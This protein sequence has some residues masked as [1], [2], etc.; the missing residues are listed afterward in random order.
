[1]P[2]PSAFYREEYAEAARGGYS[3]EDELTFPKR[4]AA[5]L[6]AVGPGPKRVLDFGCGTGAG[7]KLLIA[8]GHTVTGVDASESGIQLARAQVPSGT[9]HHLDD[10]SDLPFENATFDACVC[11]EV[12]EHLLDVRGFLSEMHRVLVP[13]GILFIT[14]PY[15]GWLKNLLLITMNFDRHFN[16]TGEHIRFFSRPSLVA[17]LT[18]AGF[19]VEQFGGIGRFWPVWKSMFVVA[20]NQS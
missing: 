5:A 18:E 12:I 9:F 13:G 10:E 16:A 17:C 4:M 1:M 11:T 6:S 3:P 19:Q 8:A 7:S 15:H 14:T 2:S 20:R